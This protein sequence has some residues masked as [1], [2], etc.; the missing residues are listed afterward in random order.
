MQ[1]RISLRWQRLLLCAVLAALTDAVV[2]THARPLYPRVSFRYEYAPLAY[3]MVGL[4][5]SSVCAQGPKGAA[6]V[7][8]L[9]G[10]VIYGTFN[11]TQLCIR[12]DW[13]L[14]TAAWDT[15]YG[16]VLFSALSYATRGVQETNCRN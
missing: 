5:V 13:S 16:T 7:G 15:L 14:G 10:F 11:A 8:A 1:V 3:A 9:L 4:A 12:T 6:S 2:L